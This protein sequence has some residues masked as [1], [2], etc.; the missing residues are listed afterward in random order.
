MTI[1][2]GNSGQSGKLIILREPDWT[3]EHMQDINAGD[4]KVIYLDKTN[5]MIMFRGQDGQSTSYGNVTPYEPVIEGSMYACGYEGGNLGLNS[6]VI[7]VNI[8]NFTVVG[9]ESVWEKITASDLFSV[10]L[11]KN[12]TL[13]TCGRNTFGQLGVNLNGTELVNISTFTQVGTDTDWT[14]VDCCQHAVVAQKSDGSLWGC[15]YY[16]GAGLGATY[17]S[18]MTQIGSDTD[19]AEFSCGYGHTAAIKN[20]GTLYAWGN[21]SRGQLGQNNT[22]MIYT[23]IQVGSDSDWQ[24]IAAGCAH[25][26]AIKNNGN[27]WSWGQNSYG[28]LGTNSRTN[29][30]VPT[31]ISTNT[32]WVRCI[33]SKTYSYGSSY[34]LNSNNELWTCGWIYNNGTHY[35]STFTKFGTDT[36]WEHIAPGER[37]FLTIKTDGSLW[38][39]GYNTNGQLGLGDLVHRNNGSLT[40][41]GS[42]TDWS[43]VSCGWIHSFA[44]K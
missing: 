19:W 8:S 28:E 34:I 1:I 2:S 21:N 36:D 39:T 11:R 44:I 25:N 30:S 41:V 42:A 24:K 3:I 7:P 43:Y 13:W 18:T 38:A 6:P 22:T 35:N 10:G 4:F 20:N 12:G 27:L 17:K 31:Q 5:K 26:L 40:Q 29:R 14:D 23:P 15:G 37:F 33:A 16:Y 9:E 32:D